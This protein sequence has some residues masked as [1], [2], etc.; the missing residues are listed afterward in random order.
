M[1]TVFF[2]PD[3]EGGLAV[4]DP[5]ERHRYVLSTPE[6]VTPEV[7]ETESFER[8][9]EAA[10]SVRT[11]SFSLPNIVLATV[12]D[13]ND[14]VAHAEHFADEHLP[15]GTYSIELS[16]P[17]KLYFVV[18]SSVDLT[19]NAERMSV[20]F[21]EE[22]DVLVG[23]RSHHDQPAATVTTTSEPAHMMQAISTFGSALKATSPERSY[24]T[25]RGH[26]PTVEL[27]EEL[28]LAGLEPPETGVTIEVPA[29]CRSVFVVAPLAYYLGARVVPGETPH[30]RT[31]TGFEYSLDGP[32]GF[33]TTVERTLKR[34]FFLDC[35]CRSEGRSPVD[36]HERSALESTL[37]LDFGA[38][39]DRPLAARLEAALDIPYETIEPHLPQWKLT[40][41]V[42]PT[43]DSVEM[44][45]FLV[46]DLA[47]VRSPHTHEVAVSNVW[48]ATLDEFL[49]G[50]RSETSRGVAASSTDPPQFVRLAAADSLEQAWV[51]DGTPLGASK[52]TTEAHRNRLDRTP[53]EG[54]STVRV[55]CN[56]AEMGEEQGLVDTI[57]GDRD[58]PFDVAVEHDLTVDEL[59]EALAERTDLLHYIG[60]IDG[61]GF[62]CLDGALDAATLDS[63]GVDAF[64]LNAC[65]SYEQGMSL[66][67][68]GSIGGIVTLSDVLNRNA[69][70]M[71]RAFAGLLNAGFPLRAALEIARDEIIVGGQYLV[72]GDGGFTIAHAESGTPNLYVA[73]RADDGLRVEHRTYPTAERGMGSLF[74][75]CV[76]G[77]SEYHLSSGT[78]RTFEC[79]VAELERVLA[80]E[81]VPAK[82][83]GDLHWDGRFVAADYGPE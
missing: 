37:G 76:D 49:R 61:T 77:E 43:P 67:R 22:V 45:P 27:G 5:V 70:A 62:E 3:A 78:V 68:K 74:V 12:R 26:P 39:Y 19:A 38:L 6:S 65:Q 11:S 40:A 28:D 34:A 15:E 16:A 23:A 21:G 81:G 80:A 73:E 2:E 66:I 14:V 36:L 1:G 48:A 46:D 42:E 13:G 33:E 59:R 32:A 75:P 9:V 79:T 51:G 63:V 4:V 55:V 35:L 57:Y 69:V 60:H 24:P 17:I 44:L 41:H 54:D 50:S 29:D 53:T 7:A 31:E 58:L 30:V 83:D 71:G 52:A 10:V 47:V 56:D 18:E 25:L 72:V 8:P 20:E 64:L 82:V